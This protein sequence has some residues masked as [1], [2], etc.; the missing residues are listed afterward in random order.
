LEQ[1]YQLSPSHRRV[2]VLGQQ[3]NSNGAIV[4]VRPHGTANAVYIEPSMGYAAQSPMHQQQQQ[5]QA[6]LSASSSSYRLPSSPNV[7]IS[8]RDNGEAVFSFV[9]HHQQQQQQRRMRQ[10][11]Q[12]QQQQ[13]PFVV[14]SSSLV[15]EQGDWI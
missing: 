14:K 3:T 15:Q 6:A 9:P 5:Q 13:T 1:Q 7:N 2:S 8:T 10:Q 12:H 4:A 11:R